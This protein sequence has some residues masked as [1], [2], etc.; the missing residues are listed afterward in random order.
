[1]QDVFRVNQS[2]RLE[3]I[4][5]R[6]S[7]ASSVTGTPDCSSTF[8]AATLIFERGQWVLHYRGLTLC[9]PLIRN[10]AATHT[11]LLKKPSAPLVFLKAH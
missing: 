5:T 6:C 10:P 8:R 3:S 9:L 2:V 11:W 4:L 1:M 7:G